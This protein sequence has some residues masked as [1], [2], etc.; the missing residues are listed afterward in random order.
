MGRLVYAAITSLDGYVADADGSFDWSAPDA[1]V[2][3]FVNDLVRG[4]GTHLYGRRMYQVM[5]A[6]E[7]MDDDGQPAV[8]RDFGR[9]WRAADKVVFSTTLPSVATAR[10]RLERRF[11]PALVAGLVESAAANVSV[12]GP[13]LAGQAL[14]AGLVDDVHVFVCPVIVGGG[15]PWLPQGVR[16]NLQLFDEQRFSNG[17]VHLHY[18]LGGERRH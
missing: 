12:S 13:G 4:I 11:D 7:T 17:T 9:I 15:T 5:S 8:A 16:L 3:A 2:H 14:A 18:G 10:T 1:Q 6:W